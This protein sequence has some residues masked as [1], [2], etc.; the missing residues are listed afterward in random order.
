MLKSLT[1][2]LPLINLVL[3]VV[4]IV[5]PI[6][7][8]LG[9]LRPILDSKSRMK[10]KIMRKLTERDN[11]KELLFP[12]IRLRDNLLFR[13]TSPIYRHIFLRRFYTLFIESIRELEIEDKIVRVSNSWLDFDIGERKKKY[14]SYSSMAKKKPEDYD[15]RKDDPTIYLGLSSPEVKEH[16]EYLRQFCILMAAKI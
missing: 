16:V 4:S 8:V 12:E 10:K 9:I 15:L 5:V 14:P 6:L 1:T 3:N 13:S 11:R 2:H 7:I